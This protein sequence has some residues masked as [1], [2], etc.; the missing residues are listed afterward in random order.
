MTGISTD[1]VLWK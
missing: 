1:F